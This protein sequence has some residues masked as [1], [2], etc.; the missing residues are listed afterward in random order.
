MKLSAKARYGLASMTYLAQKQG[1]SGTVTV[2][3][4]AEGLDISKIYLEQVF[5]LLKRAGLVRSITGARGGYQLD[6][7]PASIT[8]YDILSAIEQGL[9]EPAGDTVRESALYL[10]Q[11]LDSQ[12]FAP[13]D[14]AV[15]FALRA[16]T[17]E[18]IVTEAQSNQQDGFMYFL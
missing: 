2:V 13:L 16:I 18:Q 12:V 5:S 4:V 1:A 15:E 11:A 8:A 10:E 6:R 3:D 14:K 7:S 17:L 9:F